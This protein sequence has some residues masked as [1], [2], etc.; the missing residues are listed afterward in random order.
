MFLF[1]EISGTGQ[2]SPRRYAQTRSAFSLP[3]SKLWFQS[4]SER[5]CFQPIYRLAA[6]CDDLASCGE[7]PRCRKVQ[8]QPRSVD[9]LTS[10]PLPLPSTMLSIQQLSAEQLEEEVQHI[11]LHVQR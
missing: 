10:H 2:Q 8:G 6:N 9:P 1:L 5:A 7:A 3:G 4:E 11:D